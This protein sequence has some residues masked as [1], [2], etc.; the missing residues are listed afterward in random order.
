[1]VEPGRDFALA[2]KLR[3]L[4][5]CDIDAAVIACLEQ[6]STYARDIGTRLHPDSRKALEAMKREKAK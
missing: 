6:S 2:G 5:R 1:M 4:A 3:A